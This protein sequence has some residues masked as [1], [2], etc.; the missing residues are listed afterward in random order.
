M[1]RAPPSITAL[2]VLA[3]AV[4]LL[5]CPS[6]DELRPLEP[7]D[8]AP[9]F[10]AARITGDTLE[11]ASLKGQA[12]LLNLWATWC[13]PCREEM[14]A[15]QTL[16][17]EAAARGLR[18]VGVSIDAPGSDAAIRDFLTSLGVTFTIL[19]DPGGRIERTFRT[20]GV[21]ETFLLDR[22]GRLVHHWI[23]QFDPGSAESRAFVERALGEDKT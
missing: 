2:A 22:T 4:L 16:Y 9:A 21:P 10:R 15:L 8:L 12:V 6:R 13:I 17:T 11:L 19:K 3:G 23:G 5:A 1:R 7:G 18:V 20:I 14:P